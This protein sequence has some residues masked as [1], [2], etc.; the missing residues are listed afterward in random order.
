MLSFLGFEERILL[1][2]VSRHF[3]QRMIPQVVYKVEFR[4]NIY[5]LKT[6]LKELYCYNIVDHTWRTHKLDFK[7]K[8]FTGQKAISTETNRV[9]IL[10]GLTYDHSAPF[11]YELF[12]RS[13]EFVQRGR[14][15]RPR[16]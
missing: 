6:T 10:G 1:Q 7:C 9:F 14:M 2:A 8:T 13:G 15:D 16:I 4:V 12:R 3:Y 11:A 5:L